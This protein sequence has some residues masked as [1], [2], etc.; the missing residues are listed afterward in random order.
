MM[1]KEKTNNTLIK[2][3]GLKLAYGSHLVLEN[4]N[5]E[6]EQGRCLVVMGGSG[7]GK[8]TLLKSM[9]GLLPPINGKV[10]IDGEDL[11]CDQITKNNLVLRKLGVLFQGGALWSSMTVEENVALPMQIFT[12]LSKREVVDLVS[13]KLGLVGLQGAGGFY[14]SELSGGMRKRA[15]LA[16]A[17][18][19]DPDILFLDEPSAGLDPIT[20]KRLDDLINELKESLGISLIVVTHELASIYEIADDSI[21]LDAVTKVILAKG[22]PRN[23][24]NGDFDPKVKNFLKRGIIEQN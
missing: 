3:E 10:V 7:C 20:S 12:D 5:F 18:A 23:M 21:F 8:S 14:P 15:G 2:V 11:W 19:L 24:I 9:V 13:Y 6:V 17:M 22:K 1:V 4:I 16:R